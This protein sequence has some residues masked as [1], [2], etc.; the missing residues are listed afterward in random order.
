M[1]IFLL[2]L[3]WNISVQISWYTSKDFLYSTYLGVEI[4]SCRINV[5]SILIHNVAV[6]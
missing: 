6:G 5:C 3:L 1:N 4:L 2:L